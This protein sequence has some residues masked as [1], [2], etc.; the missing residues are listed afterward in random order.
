MVQSSRRGTV[1]LSE[2]TSGSLTSVSGLRLWLVKMNAM[3]SA[4]AI[5]SGRANA[6]RNVQPPTSE[7]ERDPE[8]DAE[9]RLGER[10]PVIA[11]RHPAEP[12]RRQQNLDALDGEAEE[13]REDAPV[14]RRRPSEK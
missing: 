11:A 14:Q 2:L 10:A 7:R 13:Q 6:N 5:S 12:A 4:L 3:T 1:T 8:R 9:R